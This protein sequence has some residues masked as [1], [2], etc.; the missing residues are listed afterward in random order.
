MSDLYLSCDD[1]RVEE[2]PWFVVALLIM[3]N[4]LLIIAQKRSLGTWLGIY[5]LGLRLGLNKPYKFDENGYVCT[6][7]SSHHPSQPDRGTMSKS[8]W[9][10]LK[11]QSER[12]A[13]WP[14]P[15]SGVLKVDSDIVHLF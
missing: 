14:G 10:Q 15:M 6:I 7:S 8:F 13:I 5:G 1:L 2:R 4:L 11:S 9:V 12:H 3:I